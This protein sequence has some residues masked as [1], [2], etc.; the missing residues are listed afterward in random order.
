[1]RVCVALDPLHHKRSSTLSGKDAE[2][3]STLYLACLL[4]RGTMIHALAAAGATDDR[5]RRC[6]RN[7]L[8]R[9]LL[10]ASL[11]PGRGERGKCAQKREARDAAAAQPRQTASGRRAFN[12]SKTLAIADP[13]HSHVRAQDAHH[14]PCG[15]CAFVCLCVCDCVCVR[16]YART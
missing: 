12:R 10:P 8:N 16:V 14:V 15:E 9:D 11:R 1:M 5:F 2:G 6:Y 13:T 7:A 3:N 4:G